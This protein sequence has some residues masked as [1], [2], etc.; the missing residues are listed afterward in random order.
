MNKAM[1][2]SKGI[3]DIHQMTLGLKRVLDRVTQNENDI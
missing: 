1:D 3:N 2:E